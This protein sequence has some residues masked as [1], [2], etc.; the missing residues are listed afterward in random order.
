MLHKVADDGLQGFFVC[1]HFVVLWFW[2]LVALSVGPALKRF[3]SQHGSNIYKEAHSVNKNVYRSIKK[4]WAATS[5]RRAKFA[6]MFAW[7]NGHR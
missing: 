6:N 3:H 7:Q 4:I 2:L 5:I 1:S